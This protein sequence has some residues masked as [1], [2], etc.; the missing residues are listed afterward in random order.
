MG[1][2]DKEKQ[3]LYNK[4]YREKNKEAIAEYNKEYRKKKNKEKT[5][6]YNKEYRENN[7]EKIKNL[8]PRYKQKELEWRESEK[9]KK[10]KRIVKWRLRGIIDEDLSAVYD[11]L[12]EQT[13]CMICLKEYIDSYDRCL[14]HD[15]LTGEI[16]YICCRNCNGIILAEKYIS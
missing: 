3:R 14:D 5:A 7:K 12:I 15:H 6:E 4:Q 13:N 2:K 8:R 1:H 16:R 11:Y 10:L 9:G